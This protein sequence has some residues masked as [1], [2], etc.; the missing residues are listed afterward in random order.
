MYLRGLWY[1]IKYELLEWAGLLGNPALRLAP[2]PA[3]KIN[4]PDGAPEVLAP[5]TA[6]TFPIEIVSGS[7]AY[8]PGTGL[9]HYRYDGGAFT[10]SPLVPVSGDLFEAMLPAAGCSDVPEFYVSAQG[11]GGST[12][13]APAGAPGSVYSAVVGVFRTVMQEPLDSDPFW[14]AEAGWAF[15]QPTGGGGEYG[16]PDPTSG[17]T[18]LNVYGYN[19]NGDYPNGLGEV[20]LTST[21]LDCTG[22]SNVH[23]RFWR[24][25]GVEGKAYDRAFVRAS[26]DGMHWT[27]VWANDGLTLDY[28]WT[29]MD[30][31][32]SAVADDQ[33]AVYLRWTMGPSDG[34]WHC[35][36]WNID[37]I[38]L[39]VFEC[40]DGPACDDGIQNQGEERIDCGGPCDPCACL[41]DE[42]CEDGD[43]CNGAD[44][45]DAFGTCVHVADADCNENEVEDACDID[46]ADPDADGSVSDDLDENGVPDE[47]ECF[48]SSAP[49]P[50]RLVLPGSPVSRKV[51]YL[52]FEAG[53][54]GRSQ[55]V[56]VT[57]ADLPAP[58][59]DWEGVRLWVQQP[60]RHCENCG[61]KWVPE[62]DNPPDYG[63]ASSGGIE[64]PWYWVADLGCE[65]CWM[66]WSTYG[67]VHVSNEGIVPEALYAF[68]VL[69]D[70]CWVSMEGSYSE[71]LML[72][73]S[74]WADAVSNCTTFPCG[75]PDGVT[76]IVDVT[77]VLD[78]W[79]N[80]PGN[81]QEVRADFE[82]S[83]AGDHR[84]PDRYIGITDVTFCLGAF[85]GETYPGPGFPPP[86]PPPSCPPVVP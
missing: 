64:P 75:P 16:A 39:S 68:Q 47:C 84:V 54:P 48:E 69:D 83:P 37:D 9:L 63:C 35:C 17:Y 46:P 57:F 27:N 61:Q 4:L 30:I 23:L 11:G 24:W 55:A 78:K 6:E 79:K 34:A 76:G 40:R 20:H 60:E 67:V 65:P 36:G 12:I 28:A 26:T 41:S 38:E 25:L 15:G 74:T 71:A 2:L 7:E 18:G 43:V 45:C 5:N 62:P 56:R 49:Q 70:T 59:T 58:Y 53:D 52:S 13:V 19:L 22:L 29:P 77:A 72:S 44:V 66:D 51:R 21:A 82:G 32:I 42:T 80:L 8:V 86:S 14:S 10:T 31:D 3:L 50:D 85:L 33:P 73:S 1:D 81:I